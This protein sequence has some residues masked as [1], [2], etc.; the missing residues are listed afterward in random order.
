MFKRLRNIKIHKSIW[1]VALA[2]L[3]L[4]MSIYFIKNEHLELVEIK[5]T[6]KDINSFY[7]ILGLFVTVIY[8]F[9]QALMYVFSFRT[10]G[11]KV[12]VWDALILFL[13]RNLISV[14][15]PAG[16]FSS[17]VFFTKP[18]K[19]KGLNNTDI[20][21]ASYIYGLTGLISVVLVAIPVIGLLLL[22]NRL[23]SKE[24][25]PF[26]LL[27]LLIALVIYSVWSLLQRKLVYK[28]LLR[29]NP[30]ISIIVDNI[31]TTRLNKKHFLYT[32]I[33]SVFIEFAGIAHVYISMLALG[34][35]PTLM[36]SLIAYIIMVML[37]IM[38]PF[39]RGMGAIEVTMTYVFV[40]SGIPLTG[41]ATITLVFRFFE[42]W[43]PLLIG[44]GSFL[45]SKKNV[46]SR[47]LPVFIIFI[48]GIINVISAITPS[49]PDRIVILE[50]LLPQLAIAVSK[51]SVFVI[52]VLLIILAIYL[53]RGVKRARRITL[54]LLAVSVIGHLV[55][56]IDY[57]EATIS[58]VAFLSLLIT[59]RF[60][61]VK[62]LPL[63]RTS[64]WKIWIV[65]LASLLLY[66]VAATFFLEKHHMGFDYSF[67][68]AIKASSR[69]IFFFDSSQ[70]IPSTHFGEFFIASMYWCSG[71]LFISAI[72]LA[73]KPI[74]DHDAKSDENEIA[75][76]KLLVKNYGDSALDY[77]K[78]YHDKLF[79]FHN[80]GFLA[81]K[82][83]KN[84]AVV[85]ELPVC[86]TKSA[87][88]KLL[89]DFEK[90]A[91]ENGLRTFYYRIPEESTKWFNKLNK[92]TLFIGQE[93]ILDLE[94]FSL[95]GSKMHP[96]RNAIN[97]AKKEGYTFHIHPHP[98]KDGV[99][100]KLKQVSDEWL[101]KPGKK[102]TIFSQGMFL[103]DVIKETTIL[104][105]ENSED[106]IVAFLNIVPD[107]ANSE[108][109]YDLI[110][111]SDSAPTG[112]IY[113]LL[114]EM[115]EYFRQQGI[116]K[117][118]LGMVPFTGNTETRN[119]AERSMKFALEN[120]KPLNHF[121][122]LYLFK[123]KFKPDWVNKYLAYDSDYDLI[124][125]PAI[126]KAVSKV[127]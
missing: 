115:F 99:I 21:Y 55:K 31:N 38:S 8:L 126:L 92:K 102:E 103:A 77:F 59:H 70:Y 123:E 53:L 12:A 116:S 2:V 101:K 6:L 125:F 66:A 24:L 97:K 23:T 73:V 110:R 84:F 16:G 83:H 108:G 122:G 26:L 63:F 89:H 105:I 68:E 18:L 39:L 71:F 9:L 19:K 112:I 4:V 96:L 11:L 60:Y 65:S 106:K 13:K 3:M 57:E 17:L 54:V 46:L 64:W 88:K 111:T 43:M 119:M 45:F 94:T 75:H 78:Y 95:S 61:H 22:K 80:D 14:F 82:I 58:F 32:I 90:Y 27:T 117:V 52:G 100:Q 15:L 74:F 79:F 37:L 120:L 98:V 41:A 56:G 28:L 121:K 124:Y 47:V 109:T 127:D 86:E 69:L 5:N 35:H 72:F 113:F 44:L 114:T 34:F 67:F 51:Y 62:S 20:Y 49:I 1:Q 42:F 25:I 93:A 81:Y 40:K 10:I 48:S 33:S 118:N 76:A 91:Y 50:K 107:Y 85:L 104:S 29:F 7:L 87:K 30:G 36:V